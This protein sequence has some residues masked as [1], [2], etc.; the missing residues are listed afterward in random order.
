V[1][2]GVRACVCVCVCMCVC[3]C[4]CVCVCRFTCVFADGVG[5]E[6]THWLL[7]R[8]GVSQF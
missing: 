3:V 8:D 7:S 4:V 5:R 2:I 1:H 6:E